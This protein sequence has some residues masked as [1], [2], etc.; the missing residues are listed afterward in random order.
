M[1]FLERKVFFFRPIG[2]VF[3]VIQP[4]SLFIG[5]DH[6]PII[7]GK[8]EKYVSLLIRIIFR[9]RVY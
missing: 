3:R 6:S 7:K 5:T 4:S 8:V 2:M 9:K 1:H